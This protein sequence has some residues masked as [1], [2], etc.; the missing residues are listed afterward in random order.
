MAIWR[1]RKL[2]SSGNVNPLHYILYKFFRSW[3]TP[4]LITS[5]CAYKYNYL[6]IWCASTPHY[7]THHTNLSESKKDIICS[8]F[9]TNML[10]LKLFLMPRLEHLITF[11]SLFNLRNTR[12]TICPTKRQEVK[13]NQ[14]KEYR[15]SSKF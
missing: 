4:L 8:K 9:R 7:L 14:G 1:H 6:L 11:C 12:V 13:N 10:F 3:L 15:R 5:C 2:Q